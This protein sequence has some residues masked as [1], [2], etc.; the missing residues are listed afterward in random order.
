MDRQAIINVLI[1]G[2]RAGDPVH[3][4]LERALSSVY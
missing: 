2:Q 3:G 4:G 1:I